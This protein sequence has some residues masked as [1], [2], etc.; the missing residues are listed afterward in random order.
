MTL[1]L[2][3]AKRK[4][5]LTRIALFGSSLLNEPLT[6]LLCLLP[7]IL[8]KDLKASAWQI[9]LLVSLRPVMSLVSFYWSSLLG[10]KPRLLKANL[11]VSGVLGRLPFLFVFFFPSTGYLIFAAAMHILFSR[12][13]IPAWMEMLKRNLPKEPR[14]R[15]FSFSWMLAYAEGVGI[16]FAMGFLLDLDSGYWRYLFLG[17]GLIGLLGVFLQYRVPLEPVE[18]EPTEKL[19]LWQMVVQPW[20]DSFHLM[21]TRPD[22]ARFQWAFMWGGSGIMLVI[23]VLPFYFVETLA[24]SHTTFSTA[25]AVC[26][27]IGVVLTSSAWGKALSRYK[28]IHLTS[29]VILLFALFPA[30]LLLAPLHIGWLYAAYVLYGIAQGGSHIVWHLSGPLFAGHCDSSVYSGINV[31]MVGLRG[32]I[33]PFLGSLLAGF[34]G[35]APVLWL[36]LLACVAGALMTRLFSTSIQRQSLN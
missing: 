16:G 30:C 23:A 11:L 22:F 1:S 29:F 2:D 18:E 36:G 15:L 9:S 28:L 19:S 27:G 12:A 4:T 10:R 25:R 6:V 5:V 31:V 24:I 32:M 34:V 14:E 21:R 7:F 3:I 33:F 8:A 35:A 13:G 17:S 20:K 26:M